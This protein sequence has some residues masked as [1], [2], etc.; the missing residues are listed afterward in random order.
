MNI[1]EEVEKNEDDDKD[2]EEEEEEEEDDDEGVDDEDEEL[3]A[4]FPLLPRHFVPHY[5]LRAI[6]Y[7]TGQGNAGTMGPQI[8]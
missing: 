4:P 2:E 8:H 1:E 6:V 3:I 5:L 7:S